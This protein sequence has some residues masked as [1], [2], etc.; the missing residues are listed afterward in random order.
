MDSYSA[1]SPT[2][3]AR[4][5]IEARRAKP[6]NADD[7]PFSF[8]DVLDVVNPLQHIP[9]VNTVYRGI[10]G[11]EIKTP[12]KLLGATVIGGPIGFAAAMA[13]SVVAETT[14]RDVGEHA[15]AMFAPPARGPSAET[16]VADAREF[17][18]DA[19]Y[20]TGSYQVASA[21]EFVPEPVEALR[22][23]IPDA[24]APSRP[25]QIAAVENLP[26]PPTSAPV[27]A[28]PYRPS[29]AE[30]AITTA[31]IAAK[32]H[33][34]APSMKQPP[35]SGMNLSAG[36]FKAAGAETAERALVMP[37]RRS[38]VAPTASAAELKARVKMPAGVRAA[39]QQISP[40][41]LA[42]AARKK[43]EREP[44]SPEQREAQARKT[45]DADVPLVV[46]GW[47]DQAMLSG[48]DKYQAMKRTNGM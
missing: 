27:S 2:S 19:V 32:A 37:V 28:D 10:T 20:P 22:E 14:G 39:D 42:T 34:R 18:P 12:I 26:A 9:I 8:W 7:Q 36:R 16:Q 33:V 48:L 4:D 29:D 31:Q 15:M 30:V 40:A 46:P 6:A 45:A 38:D 3:G 1:L 24:V 47:F 13:D 44:L 35:P 25:A 43:L 17:I 11:D 41:V 21:E 5:P 23:F